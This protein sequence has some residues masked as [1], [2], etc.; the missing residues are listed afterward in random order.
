MKAELY[1]FASHPEEAEMLLENGV[2]LIQFR[3]KAARGDEYSALAR[4]VVHSARDYPN[5]RIIVNDDIRTALEAGAYGVH[6]G[7]DDGDFREICR[8]YKGRLQIGVS[9]DTVSEALEAQAAGADSIGAGA[10]FGS[11]TK[12][13]APYMGLSLLQN[14]CRAVSVPV[15]AIG[16]ITL[17]NLPGVLEA[18]AAY[19]CVISDIHGSADPRERIAAYQHLIQTTE[20]NV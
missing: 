2:S 8:R 13:D 4:R 10:V 14:I 1:G 6:L 11:R 20:V 9:V 5:A 7:Q 15:S 17:E 16:G 18:G 3:N 19:I 12:P